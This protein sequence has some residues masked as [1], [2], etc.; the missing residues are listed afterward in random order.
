MQFLSFEI[1]IVSGKWSTD[2]APKVSAWFITIWR[3]FEIKK[4]SSLPLPCVKSETCFCL[5]VNCFAS[6]FLIL[7][8]SHRSKVS[9]IIINSAIYLFFEQGE[10]LLISKV[11]SS[12]RF[13]SR[14]SIIRLFWRISKLSRR[15]CRPGEMEGRGHPRGEK[16]SLWFLSSYYTIFLESGW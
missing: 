4:K 12:K 10:P 1:K 6:G 5:K 13:K 15:R 2:K 9:F 7:Q 8:L 11:V 3:L 16:F 14:A